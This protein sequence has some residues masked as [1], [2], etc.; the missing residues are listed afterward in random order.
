MKQYMFLQ[1]AAACYSKVGRHVAPSAVASRTK[2]HSDASSLQRCSSLGHNIGAALTAFRQA[3]YA[4]RGL[5][6]AIAS[7]AKDMVVEEV[8]PAPMALQQLAGQGHAAADA[9]WSSLVSEMQEVDRQWL[10]RKSKHAGAAADGK[11]IL[12][13]VCNAPGKFCSCSSAF[14][15]MLLCD[16]CPQVRALQP[17]H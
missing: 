16:A 7:A 17:A 11:T 8:M 3:G 6:S 10:S 14:A 4:K 15:F 13:H 2:H 9:D 5:R 12:L 1:A